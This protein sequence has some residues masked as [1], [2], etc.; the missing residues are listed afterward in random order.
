MG[1]GKYV[2]PVA[3]SL[4]PV[5]LNSLCIGHGGL[6]ARRANHAD[7]QAAIFITRLWRRYTSRPDHS[8]SCPNRRYRLTLIGGPCYSETRSS[9]PNLERL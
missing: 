9:P 8:R 4:T 5:L 1:N 7:M 2:A 3:G 6:Q